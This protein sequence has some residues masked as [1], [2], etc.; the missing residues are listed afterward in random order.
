MDMAGFAINLQLIH[1]YPDAA[2]TNSVQRGYQES[3]LLSGLKISQD[4]LEP[5]ANM[6]TEVRYPVMLVFESLLITL[7]IIK[8]PAGQHR[9][10]Y[11]SETSV[12][13]S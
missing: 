1:D 5:K 2:F 13:F 10:S 4:D 3:T 9:R 7:V 8:F 11:S 6:C 12:L